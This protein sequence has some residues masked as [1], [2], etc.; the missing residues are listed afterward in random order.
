MAR[1]DGVVG[2]GTSLRST[3]DMLPPGADASTCGDVDNVV[4]LVAD[5]SVAG[6]CSVIDVL[7]GL[8][9]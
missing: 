1:S 7:D 3:D 5:A 8:L 4:V 6:N 9:G 2:I